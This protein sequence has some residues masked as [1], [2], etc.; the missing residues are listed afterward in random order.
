MDKLTILHLCDL[1]FSPSKCRDIDIVKKALFEDLNDFKGKSIQ[2]DIVIFSGDLIDKGDFGYSEQ[3]NDYDGVRTEFIYPLLELLDLDTDHFLICAGNHDIQRN[4]VDKVVESGLRE[5]LRD[6]QSMNHFIDNLDEEKT[7]FYLARMANFEEFK[8]SINSKLVRTS[9]VLFSTYILPKAGRK[10]GIA[11]INSAW[12]AYG[13]KGDNGREQDY[14]KLLI[15]ERTVDNCIDAL[16]DCDL[17]IGVVHHP[18][19]YLDT[20][21][22]IHLKWRVSQGFNIWLQGHTHHP[23]PQLVQFPEN[24]IVIVA[25]GALY[26]SREYYN[27]YSLIRYSLTESAGTVYLREYRDKTRR[28]V[29]N[30]A[31]GDEGIF[32]FTLPEAS[33]APLSS[34]YS[35]IVPIRD[36]VADQINQAL[37]SVIV[38]QSIAPKALGEVFVEPPLATESEYKSMSLETRRRR[39]KTSRTLD[40]ILESGKN[41]L[42]IGKKESGKT[43][44]LN[45]IRMRYLEPDT[46]TQIEIPLFVDLQILPKGKDKVKNV[47][48][49]YNIPDFQLCSSLEENMKLGNCI[50]LV[51][52][53]DLSDKKALAALVEFTRDYSLNR[54]MLAIDEEI[55]ADME[56]DKLPDLG[57]DYDRIYIHSFGRKEVRGLISNWFCASSTERVGELADTILLHLLDTGMPRTPVVISLMLLIMEQQP[58]YIP[59]NK[60]SLLE[61]LI[62]ILL[63]KMNPLSGLEGIDYRTKEH[64]L[65]HVAHCMVRE[66]TKFRERKK[67]YLDFDEFK[68]ETRS[69]FENKGLIIPGG[70]QSFIDYFIGKGILIQDNGQIDFRFG[71]FGEFFVAKHMLENKSFYETILEEDS[72][73]NFASEIDYLTGLQRTNR[74]L[75]ALLSQRSKKSLEDCLNQVGLEIELQHFDDVRLNKSLLDLLPKDGRATVVERLRESRLKEEQKDELMDMAY[76]LSREDTQEVIRDT[77][78]DHRTRL[79][80]ILD[81]FSRVIKNCELIDDKKFK[82]ENVNTCVKSF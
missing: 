64:F 69:Y 40:E 7:Q 46:F 16:A 15:G 77:Y 8:K 68:G 22:R 55:F 48:F 47:I 18:F 11:C 60:A 34:N 31:Y 10:I 20:F 27:G 66:K 19:E 57:V 61:N 35:L 67:Y 29:K 38:E 75:V 3:R 24:R 17:R 78:K 59:I 21:E 23:D 2:P 45:Y 13:G 81:L 52:N 44:L 82:K 62:E 74:D 39:D 76:R 4:K 56:L 53:L 80:K 54:Y 1:H 9:N 73:L 26:Q 28:F 33:T 37:L 50:F 58:D 30:L 5:T 14:G 12:R 79:V 71:C 63:E 70:V 6:R 36:Y 43:T 25:G 72:Y 49:N 41:I 42:F 65:S 32:Q 51:D